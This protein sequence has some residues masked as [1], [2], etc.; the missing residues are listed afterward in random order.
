MEIP[1][2]SLADRDGVFSFELLLLSLELLKE[3]PGGSLGSPAPLA[4]LSR[5]NSAVEDVVGVEVFCYEVL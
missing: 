4:L 2:G 3:M 5:V 1:G